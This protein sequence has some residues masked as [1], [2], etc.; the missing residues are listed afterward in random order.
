MK[1]GLKFSKIFGGILTLYLFFSN[2]FYFKEINSEVITKDNTFDNTNYVL[3]PGDKILIKIFELD[4]YNSEVI[5]LPD[6]TINL[7]RL[8]LLNIKGLSI[9]E[10]QDLISK[11]Y[12]KIIKNPIIYINL[13]E[14]RPT[15]VTISGEV[16]NPGFYVMENQNNQ[17]TIIQ[18]LKL[19]GGLSDQADIRNITLKRYNPLLN[20]IQSEKFNFWKML[21]GEM[22]SI[23]PIVYDGDTI[24]VGKIKNVSSLELKSLNDTNLSAQNIDINILGEV[25]VPGLLK[26][27]SNSTLND[28]IIAAGGPTRYANKKVSL[29]RLLENGKVMKNVYNYDF[30]QSFNS[31]KN[32][33]LRNRDLIVIKPNALAK[34]ERTLSD[35]T[36]PLTPIVN[37]LSIYNFLNE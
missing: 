11:A 10:A 33:R 1:S 29:F 2:F 17:S 22:L 31:S 28:A 34:V 14:A 12:M 26:L 8:D 35:V 3:G 19:A 20:R 37:A 5:V 36:R 7:P 4:K 25:N 30:M 27:K 13:T 24:H 16:L 15:K 32:P 18:A 9:N 21:N 6:G 23:D